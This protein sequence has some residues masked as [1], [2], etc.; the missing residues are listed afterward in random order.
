MLNPRRPS[1]TDPNLDFKIDGP[2]PYKGC[3]I[4]APVSPELRPISL[5]IDDIAKN[6]FE[7]KANAKD[8][9]HV[10]NIKEIPLTDRKHFMQSIID[11]L[12]S[13]EGVVF[14]D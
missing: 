14:I 7:Q 11:K 1:S 8:V 3:D 12:G 2:P 10:V 5:Q 9:L 6:I 13:P 4:K